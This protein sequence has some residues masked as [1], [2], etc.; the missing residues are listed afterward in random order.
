MMTSYT[1]TIDGVSSAQDPDV[2]LTIA[3]GGDIEGIQMTFAGSSG[4]LMSMLIP[5]AGVVSMIEFA[6]MVAKQQA[7]DA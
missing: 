2:Q 1:M 7:R 6:A 4:A 5:V 3:A